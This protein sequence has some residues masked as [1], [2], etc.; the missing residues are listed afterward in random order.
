VQLQQFQLDLQ[1][2]KTKYRALGG[3]CVQKACHF[4]LVQVPNRV[5]SLGLEAVAKQTLPVPL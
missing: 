3:A 5:L 2:G 4:V 1:V